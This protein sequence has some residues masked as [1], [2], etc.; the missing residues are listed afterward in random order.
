MNIHTYHTYTC[1]LN[2][3]LY[4][5]IYRYYYTF[6]HPPLQVR[7]SRS[8][9]ASAKIAA[10][11][12]SPTSPSMS[13]TSPSRNWWGHRPSQS[14][15]W[16]WRNPTV[17]KRQKYGWWPWNP[18]WPCYSHGQP[19]PCSKMFQD[20]P[21]RLKTTPKWPSHDPNHMCFFRFQLEHLIHLH[22]IISHPFSFPSLI[23]S[24]SFHHHSRFFRAPPPLENLQK[25]TARATHVGCRAS[26]KSKG[27]PYVIS[28]V[29]VF[30][31]NWKA[32]KYID[33][34]IS[35]IPNLIQCVTVWKK[36]KKVYYLW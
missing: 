7:I 14:R 32:M 23:N 17:F 27:S 3:L 20:V 16:P 24:Q 34:H 19:W 10:M 28:A 6:L 25:P 5:V 29:S 18:P 36:M 22:L 21:S 33:E 9:P 4:S 31:R 15:S 35:Y 8:F 1:H 11:P 30:P 26:E 2:N 13:P 12:F